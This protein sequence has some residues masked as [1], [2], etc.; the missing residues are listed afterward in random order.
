[1]EYYAPLRSLW[2]IDRTHYD[3]VYQGLLALHTQL[4]L[5]P[6]APMAITNAVFKIRRDT[7]PS[8]SKR[9][10][11][12]TG[13]LD[14]CWGYAAAL[15]DLLPAGTIALDAPPN[16]PASPS[17][18][19]RQFCRATQVARDDT[20]GTTWDAALVTA[21][22]WTPDPPPARVVL[23]LGSVDPG[24]LI[25]WRAKSSASWSLAT[26]LTYFVMGSSAP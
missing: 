2:D 26:E 3:T 20:D 22:R 24:A 9:L 21:D 18:A 17:T 16:F 15:T 6:W 19:M 8:T 14:T 13:D 12:S 11:L 7:G 5:P 23:L 4:A 10:L 25:A 1:M